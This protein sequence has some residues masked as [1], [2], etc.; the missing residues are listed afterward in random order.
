MKIVRI[1]EDHGEALQGTVGR[2]VIGYYDSYDYDD[3]DIPEEVIELVKKDYGHMPTIY[4]TEV[5]L[6]MEE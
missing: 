5:L 4:G 6:Y 2:R 1:Y 3:N